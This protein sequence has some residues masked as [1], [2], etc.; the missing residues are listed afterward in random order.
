MEKG[1]TYEQMWVTVG[2]EVYTFWNNS[3]LSIKGII[4]K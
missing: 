4:R 2:T 3:I 1:E